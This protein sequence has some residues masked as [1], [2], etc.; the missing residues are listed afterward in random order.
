MAINPTAEAILNAVEKIFLSPRIAVTVFFVC[1]TAL[2]FGPRFVES[3]SLIQQ[4]RAWLWLL[5][6]ASD[7]YSVT[8]PAQWVWKASKT[9]VDRLRAKHRLAER[10]QSLTVDEKHILQE[11][12][13]DNCRVVAW[14]LNRLTIASLANDGIIGLIQQQGTIGY[15]KV[16]DGPWSYLQQHKEML[17]TPGT[18]RPKRTGYEWMI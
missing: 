13:E 11:H 16:R 3:A 6:L 14:S 7:F 15:F 2:P 4:H 12:F 10:L 8:F 9:A 18:P 1:G 17:A 5:F